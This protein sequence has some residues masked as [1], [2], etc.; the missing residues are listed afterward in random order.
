[1]SE[2]GT[3]WVFMGEGATHPSAVFSSMEQAEAWIKKHSLGG[4]LTAYPIDAPIYELAVARGWFKPKND[5]QRS[6]RF[7]QRF[8][9]ASQAHAHYEEG[10]KDD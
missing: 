9:S 4:I 10:H 5:E 2:S 7:I 3:V 6:S 1:M 8:S